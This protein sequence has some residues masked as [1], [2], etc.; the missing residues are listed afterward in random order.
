MSKVPL[1]TRC[2]DTGP[3]SKSKGDMKRVHFAMGAGLLQGIRESEA[4]SHLYRSTSLIYNNNQ[5]DSSPVG[6]KRHCTQT[7]DPKSKNGASAP[8][9]GKTR[10]KD[11]P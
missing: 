11:A 7:Q 9:A 6:K 4:S 1:Y 10:K 5:R 2:K 3:E 8:Y